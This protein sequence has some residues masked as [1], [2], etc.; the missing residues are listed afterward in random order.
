LVI[1]SHHHADHV[2]GLIPVITHYQPRL[3][4][5]N[6]LAHP[7]RTYEDL[8]LAIAAA[9]SGLLEPTGQRIGLGEAALQVLPPPSIETWGQDDN[10]VGVIVEYGDF[11][12][13]LTGDAK[14]RLFQ[15]W[16]EHHAERIAPVQVYKSSHHGSH[17][18]D[19]PLN[20]SMFRPEVVVIGVG[21]GNPYG[22]PREEALALYE[23]AGATVYRTDL[24][25]TVIITATPEGLYRVALKRVT[26]QTLSVQAPAADAPAPCINLNTASP[27]E[28]TGILHIDEERSG[29]ILDLRQER[30][31]SS[32]KEMTR[33]RGIAQGRLRDI[34]EEGRACVR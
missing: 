23:A 19:T 28:L 24:H 1:A 14:A 29:Q 33:V 17:D 22:H 31:F 26:P 12:A 10:S 27:G 4:M 15:Y 13:G 30:P 5:E 18:G 20:M 6:G 32:V 8:L 25:G 2:G 3:V 7:T 9:G 34:L 16:R 21:L 11:R